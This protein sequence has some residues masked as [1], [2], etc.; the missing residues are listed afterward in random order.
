MTERTERRVAAGLGAGGFVVDD[1]DGAAGACGVE[2]PCASGEE[3]VFG[4][5]DAAVFFFPVGVGDPLAE[6]VANEIR[7]PS[8]SSSDSVCP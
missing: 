1:A 4:D 5:A 3:E 7:P 8:V 2:L 6:G